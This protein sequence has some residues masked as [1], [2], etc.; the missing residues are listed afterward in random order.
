MRRL[1]EARGDTAVFTFGRFNP[2]T[3]GH[4]KLI[5]ALDKQVVAGA[6]MYVYPSHSQNAKK[7]PLP[8]G[9]KVAYMKKMFPKYAK[10]ITVSR[11]RN[12]FEI[13]VELFNKSLNIDI[14][15]NISEKVSKVL[16]E[17]KQIKK[18]SVPRFQIKQ[19]KYFVEF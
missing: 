1:L 3:T 4:E 18:D 8:H 13:A 14:K 19:G 12:V 16:E 15:L 7:D 2:P 6:K 5:N 10:N 17:K 11:A 9:R